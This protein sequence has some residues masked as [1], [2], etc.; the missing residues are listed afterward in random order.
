MTK[1]KLQIQAILLL[2]VV[3]TIVSVHR[4]AI[5]KSTAIASASW[6]AGNIDTLRSFTL[7]DVVDFLRAQGEMRLDEQLQAND[8]REFTWA[9]LGGTGQD[10]L[11]VVFE[12]L[13]AIPE[14]YLSIY[15]RDPSGKITSQTI[16]GDEIR[17]KVRGGE[18]FIPDVIES[19]NGSDK[20]LLVIPTVFVFNLPTSLIWPK[21]YALQNGVYIAAGPDSAS[22]YDAQIL[23]KFNRAIA[24]VD[25]RLRSLAASNEPSTTSD[26]SATPNQKQYYVRKRIR[27]IMVRDK[28]LRFIGRD[29]TAGLAQARMWISDGEARPAYAVIKDI[30]D[31]E[32]DLRAAQLEIQ[33]GRAAHN[34]KFLANQKKGN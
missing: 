12:S 33:R 8:I 26:G 9:D 5:A 24:E 13:G 19:E 7:N 11:L 20:K 14:S 4:V 1:M 31:H 29:P 15:N 10:S 21:A 22:F 32:E 16:V 6:N 17:L 28:I 30:G 23:P 3:L 34:A 18:G 27:L 2:T 25:D